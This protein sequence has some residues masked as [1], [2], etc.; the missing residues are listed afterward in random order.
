M[1]KS[2]YTHKAHNSSFAWKESSSKHF[3]Q[4][5][6]D[7]CFTNMQKSQRHWVLIIYLWAV[8]LGNDAF[9]LWH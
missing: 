9:I 1:N 4:V 7:F 6:K 5:L 3:F 2:V 8:L